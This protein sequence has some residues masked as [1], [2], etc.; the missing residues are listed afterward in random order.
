MTI[1]VVSVEDP[2]LDRKNMNV[3][4]YAESRDITQ[5]RELPSMK[6]VRWTIRDLTKSESDFCDDRGA[7]SHMAKLNAAMMFGLVK[8]DNGREALVPTHPIPDRESG[9]SKMVWTDDELATI[10]ADYGKSVFREIS[11]IIC[12]RD[13]RSGK[14]FGGGVSSYT[15]LPSSLSAL[16]KIERQ[17]AA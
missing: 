7:T 12:Q 6:V 14:A 16:E 1:E 2:A 15:L 9:G 10:Q 8:I 5:V 13:E 11:V 3:R 4:K 17:P